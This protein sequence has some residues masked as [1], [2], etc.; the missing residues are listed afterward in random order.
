MRTSTAPTIR[1]GS[2]SCVEAS[3]GS[4]MRRMF[5]ASV[6]GL[7]LLAI[8]VPTAAQDPVIA[9]QADASGGASNPSLSQAGTLA[10]AQ[11]P[12]TAKPVSPLLDSS[13]SLFDPSWNMFQL[14]G[15][16]SSVDGDPARWQRYQD[17][18]DGLLFT[19]GRVLRETADWSASAT[20][21]NVGWRDQRY[22][23]WY[24]RIGRFTVTG[25]WDQIPQFYSI[26]TATPFTT[27][28]EGVL[29]LDDA[30]QRAAN[31]NVYPP[32]SPQFDLRERRDIGSFHVAA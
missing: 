1:Q 15:R 10:A 4:A 22:S 8:S 32:I 18:R 17:L 20:A 13:R 16:V 7:L 5:L 31:L 25:L 19:T 26:D 23:G 6:S 14:S 28:G 30:A 29:V 27:S 11:S 3:G 9:G 21:D 24:E 12:Q 2:S